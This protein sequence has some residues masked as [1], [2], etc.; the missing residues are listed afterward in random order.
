[1]KSRKRVETQLILKKELGFVLKKS[2]VY[3]HPCIAFMQ[4]RGDP[5]LAEVD[6][7]SLSGGFGHWDKSHWLNQGPTFFI[8]HT[9]I[10]L[11]IFYSSLYKA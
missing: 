10:S 3:M 6:G 8:H 7:K 4:D 5:P 11:C 9:L 2:G 1:M